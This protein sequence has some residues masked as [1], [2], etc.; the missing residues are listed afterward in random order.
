MRAIQKK[1]KKGEKNEKQKKKKKNMQ[2]KVILSEPRQ[3]DS[4]FK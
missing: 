4:G 2:F 3:N 1:K